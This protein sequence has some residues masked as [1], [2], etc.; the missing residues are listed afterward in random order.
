MNVLPLEASGIETEDTAQHTTADQ[1][2]CDQGMN[3][4]T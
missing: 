2:L 4:T 1:T 3:K